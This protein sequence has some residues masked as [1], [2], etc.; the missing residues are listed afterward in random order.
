M[1]DQDT[2]AAAPVPD[3]TVTADLGRVP[4]DEMIVWATAE[5]DRIDVWAEV[6]RDEGKCLDKRIARNRHIARKVTETLVLLKMVEKEFVAMIRQRRE[7]A[8]A[9]SRAR[10]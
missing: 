2:A 8:E 4:L 3:D 6:L 5:A 1:T 9:K 7:T 10:R